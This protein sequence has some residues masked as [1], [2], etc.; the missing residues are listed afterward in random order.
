MSPP[1]STNLGCAVVYGGL[2]A[3]AIVFALLSGGG[4]TGGIAF[5]LPVLLG[6]PWTLLLGLLFLVPQV[7]TPIT[8]LVLLLVPPAINIFLIL[9]IRG[10]VRFPRELPPDGEPGDGA[11][12]R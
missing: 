8:A 3:V 11:G 10:I 2:Y 7:P 9:R 12:S 1:N 4:A 5:V 6:L